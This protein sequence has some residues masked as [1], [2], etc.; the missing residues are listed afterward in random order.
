M[1]E[2]EENVADLFFFAEGDE[3]L[4]KAEACRVVN[5]AEL[6]DRDQI[7]S[8]TDLCGFMRIEKAKF[9]PPR[10]LGGTEKLHR[11][12]AQSARSG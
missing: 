2:Q 12:F 5:A 8:A 6:E 1:L 9:L 4:L 10:T 3:L 7:L 11:S